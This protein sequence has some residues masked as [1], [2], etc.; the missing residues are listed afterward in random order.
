[1]QN[2][3][4]TASDSAQPEPDMVGQDE[5][6]AAQPGKSSAGDGVS[7][8]DRPRRRR[9]A[10]RA[11]TDKGT[12]HAGHYGVQSRDPLAALIRLGAN[13]RQLLKIKKK[14]RAELKPTGILGDILLDRAWSSYLRC[15]L[16]ARVEADLFVSVDQDDSDRMPEL[17]DMDLPTLVFSKAGPTNYSFSDDLMKHLETALRYDG[18]YAR[19][20]W[21][22]VG[23]LIAM[24]NG[25]LA[26]LLDC[27]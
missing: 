7:E 20:F 16:I 12:L 22:S 25:G 13:R 6:V 24:Q 17:K 1:M 4:T 10:T 3:D 14:L 2:G 21:W 5:T 27:L 15:L 9:R 8:S 23:S 18:H 11:R 26:G 19:Q